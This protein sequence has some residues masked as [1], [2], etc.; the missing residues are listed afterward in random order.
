MTDP[1]RT[2]SR[3]VRHGEV[4][5]ARRETLRAAVTAGPGVIWLTVFL[6]VPLLS[7]AAIAF[8]SRGDYGEVV[9]E[10]TL[11]NF[12]RFFGFGLFGFEP[13]Y[14][15]IVLRSLA[16]AASTTA[17][18]AAA[19]LPLS[20]FVASLRGRFRDAALMLIVVPFW[21]NL[22]IRT[23]AWQMLL[24]GQGWI[25]RT[26]ASLG[27]LPEGG[28]LYPGTFAVLVGMTCDFL[29]FLALPL[30]ASVEKIDWTLAEAAADLGANGW[31]VF[32][33]ALLPQVAPG[34]AAGCI[35]VFIGATGQFVVPDLLGGAKSVLLGNVIQQQ[36]GLSRDW[37]F[38]SAIACFAMALVMTGLWLFRRTAGQ[39]G[40]DRFL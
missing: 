10:F 36:F 27:L 1:R 22:L 40:R 6:F 21:T 19:A 28:A 5:D 9:R 16:L 3:Y 4:L 24:S 37:P 23:Y 30:Y 32:R 34:L 39:E 12:K 7:I 26:A 17:L 14:P 11:D 15:K 8:A 33:H 2:S 38:G 35:L 25:A 20:F 31:K 13:L 29:P 18:C